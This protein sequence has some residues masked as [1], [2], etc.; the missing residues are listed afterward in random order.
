MDSAGTGAAAPA[1]ARCRVR[2]TGLFGLV[3]AVLG[4]GAAPLRAQYPLIPSDALDAGALKPAPHLGGYV[5]LLTTVRNDSTSFTLNRG[6]VTVTTAPLPYLAVKIQGDLSGG[7][8][9]HVSGD[10][11]VR[12]FELT[13]AYV[14]VAPP[15]A[16]GPEPAWRPTLIVGQFKQPF[17]LEYLTSFA[18]LRTAS[19]SLAVNELAPKRDIGVQGQVTWRSLVTAALSATN[20]EGANALENRD[21]R[22]LVMGRLTLRPFAW[23]AVAGKVAGEGADHARG[24]DARLAWR[25][26]IVE[27]EGLHRSRPLPGGVSQDAGGGYALAAYR[28]LPWLQPVFKQEWYADSRAAEGVSTTR[29]QRWSTAGINVETPGEAVRLQ[30]DW[31]WKSERPHPERNDELDVQ[32]IANF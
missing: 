16:A 24:Y 29:R 7:V 30:V 19:R 13:D 14:Q 21:G 20:G 6:R 9:G 2:L 3:V 10:S 26:L 23:L 22:E 25:R 4:A 17:S 18:Y 31:V 32:V 5:S 8:S 11:A 12:G 1:A 15:A 27:G 28:V